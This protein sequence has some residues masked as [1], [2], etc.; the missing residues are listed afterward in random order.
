MNRK[1]KGGRVGAFRPIEPY[2]TFHKV[3]DSKQYAKEATPPEQK[4]KKNKLK[5]ERKAEGEM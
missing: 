2:N 3:G 1:K 4:K 5:E